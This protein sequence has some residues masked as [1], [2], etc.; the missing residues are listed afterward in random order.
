MFVQN[1]AFKYANIHL[2]KFIIVV[3]VVAVVANKSI[4]LMLELFKHLKICFGIY[5]SIFF[6][7][8]FQN[9][10]VPLKDFETTN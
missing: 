5:S 4:S 7:L 3:I 6:F 8:H 1:T 10:F 2:R 9:L